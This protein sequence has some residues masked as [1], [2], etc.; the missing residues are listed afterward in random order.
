VV[1]ILIFLIIAILAYY[2][3]DYIER[4]DLKYNGVRA[5]GTIIH[6]EESFS[7][8]MYRLGGNINNPT[9]KFVTA[10]GKEIIGKPIIGFVS[11][12]EVTVPSQISI[13]Y[14]PK[15]PHKFMIPSK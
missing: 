5:V 6:N 7:K 11:Q 3:Y 8:S 12:H 9:I 15:N 14:D 13:I 4:V 1:Y 2:C 10:D